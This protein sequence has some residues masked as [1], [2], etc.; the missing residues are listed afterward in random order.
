MIRTPLTASIAPLLIGSILLQPAAMWAQNLAGGS[1]DA[2]ANREMARR[3]A[4][5]T[6]GI[7]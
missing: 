2:A 5:E 3:I 6:A 4:R 1:V 7:A